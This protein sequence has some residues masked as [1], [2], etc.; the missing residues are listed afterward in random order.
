MDQLVTVLALRRA[1]ASEEILVFKLY[2]PV[3]DNG[4]LTVVADELIMDFGIMIQVHDGFSNEISKLS[5]YRP[6][7][8]QVVTIILLSVPFS[9]RNFLGLRLSS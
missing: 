7:P 1:R 4:C 2:L 3:H 6:G 5:P 8:G 9:R